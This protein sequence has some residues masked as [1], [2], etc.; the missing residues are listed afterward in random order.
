MASTTD[1]VNMAFRRVESKDLSQFKNDIQMF[2]ILTAMDGRR[3]I[4]TIARDDFYEVDVLIEKVNQL[5]Q[6][7]VLEPVQGN[8]AGAVVHAD[9]M[10]Y[11]QAELTKLVGPVAGMLLKDTVAKLGHEISSFPKGKVGELLDRV[12]TFIQNQNKAE[13]FKRTMMTRLR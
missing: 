1:M 5:V 10:K 3:S 7:G 9:A 4:G 6:M 8:G 13:D 2:N 12:A 11:L